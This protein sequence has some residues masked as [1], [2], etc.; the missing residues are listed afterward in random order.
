MSLISSSSAMSGLCCVTYRSSALLALQVDQFNSLLESLQ[1]MS[2][3]A[4]LVFQQLLLPGH[5]LTTEMANQKCHQQLNFHQRVV[6]E[7][8]QET[9]VGLVKFQDLQAAPLTVRWVSAELEHL[10]FLAL[11][12][13]PGLWNLTNFQLELALPLSSQ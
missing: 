8:R 3:L 4:S 7:P 9:L 10:Q 13:G 1:P 5:L 11:A 6:A 12:P 2:H